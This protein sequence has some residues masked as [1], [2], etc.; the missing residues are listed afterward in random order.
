LGIFWKTME[1]KM[2][3]FILVIYNILRPLGLWLMGTWY[4]FPPLWY[5]VPRKIWQ[6][7][8][9]SKVQLLNGFFCKKK[10][11]EKNKTMLQNSCQRFCTWATSACVLTMY[12]P[13]GSEKIKLYKIYSFFTLQ[14]LLRNVYN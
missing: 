10:C 11:F 2:L 13:R 14:N 8:D 6:P 12:L 3:L 7:C 1:W 5:I 9:R 4:I